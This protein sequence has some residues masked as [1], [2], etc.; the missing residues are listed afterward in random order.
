MRA[1]IPTVSVLIPAYNYARYLPEAIESV[2]SQSYSDFELLIVD[3]CS[4]DDTEV[5]CRKYMEKD[6]RVRYIRNADNIGMFRN[7]NQSL[8]HANGTYIK[9]L[10]A[11]D[12]FHP[13]LLKDFVKIFDTYANVSLVTSYK[14]IFDARSK[15]IKQ[16]FHGLLKGEEAIIK[17]LSEEGNWIGEPTTVMFKREN[18][19]MGL[20]DPSLLMFAD[21]DMWLRQLQLGDIYVIDKVLSYF[22]EHP[23]Q[24]TKDLNDSEDK[25][26]FSFLQ[27]QEYK[28]FVLQSNKF[29][30]NI[31]VKYP[32]EAQTILYY[33]ASNSMKYFT[34]AFADKLYSKHFKIHMKSFILDFLSYLPKKNI[35]RFKK[36]L[37][38]RLAKPK[39]K[40]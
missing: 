29:G 39:N 15:I 24:G 10:N 20:F 33:L 23:C 37:N 35:V 2:L 25:Q 1:D 9:F 11:D 40:R 18:L 12:K 8:L 17:A 19:T 27:F 3:N 14:E 7:Y 22:R 36:S 13:E 32:K 4:T 28:R 5:L 6:E 30:C 21:F 26:A 38:K 31:Q 16:P 34:Y